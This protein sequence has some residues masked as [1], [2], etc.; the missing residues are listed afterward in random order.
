MKTL[1]LLVFLALSPLLTRAA[2]TN[3]YPPVKF[4]DVSGWGKEYPTHDAVAGDEHGGEAQYGSHSVL[5]TIHH[6]TEVGTQLGRREVTRVP[7]V[8]E[9]IITT[10]VESL[11]QNP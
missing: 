4:P 11:L 5:R 9:P 7:G 6:R 2:E 10:N 1:L 3:T 8:N